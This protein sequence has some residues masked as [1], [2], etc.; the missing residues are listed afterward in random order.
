MN[1]WAE[2]IEN[3]YIYRILSQKHVIWS[4]LESLLIPDACFLVLAKNDLHLTNIDIL[5]KFLDFWYGVSK[6]LNKILTYIQQTVPRPELL[7]SAYLSSSVPS[8]LE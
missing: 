6:F 8:R 1:I 7:F 2:E 3:C 5:N 4:M